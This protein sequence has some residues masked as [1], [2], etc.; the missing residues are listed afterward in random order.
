MNK[1]IN[2]LWDL[3]LGNS[4]GATILPKTRCISIF[5]N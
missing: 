1:D 2:V 4:K 3:F 5:A